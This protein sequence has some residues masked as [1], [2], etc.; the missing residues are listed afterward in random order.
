MLAGAARALDG[1]LLDGADAA[2]AAAADQI[3][4][5]LRSILT[6][7]LEDE[8][9]Y[10]PAPIPS[11]HTFSKASLSLSRK[12][13]TAGYQAYKIEVSKGVFLFGIKFKMIAEVA[14]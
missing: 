5:L 4:T 2:A 7:P 11:G 3:K 9:L 6:C 10:Q 12:I 13:K 14:L 8:L 1:L